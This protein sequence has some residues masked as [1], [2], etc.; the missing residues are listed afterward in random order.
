[1]AK[2]EI[3]MI[4][5]I[6]LIIF[7]LNVMGF[8]ADWQLPLMFFPS[9]PTIAYSLYELQFTHEPALVFEGVKF[10]ACILGSIPCAILFIVNRKQMM[11]KGLSS[12]GLK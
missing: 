10:A 1:M 5:N 4:S 7:I 11:E 9:Y 2:I 3:P 6:T 8:W 12:G